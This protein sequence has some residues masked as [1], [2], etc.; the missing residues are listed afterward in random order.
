GPQAQDV[1]AAVGDFV[2]K[3]RDGLYAYQLAVVVDDLAM[4]VTEVVRGLDLLD[5]TARQIQ[6]INALGGAAPD[7]IHVPLIVDAE[8]DKLSKRHGSLTLRSLRD[9]GVGAPQLA[10]YLA[11]S[12]GLLD[13]P[14]PCHPQGLVS[15]FSWARVTRD[16]WVLPADPVAVLLEIT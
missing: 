13:A 8:G 11:Y 3:R 7:W 1:A 9:A 2:L 6:L 15:E 12:A 4:G 14:R 10:G 5:S 16:P